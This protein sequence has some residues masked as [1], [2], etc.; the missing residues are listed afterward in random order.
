[1]C[2]CSWVRL[3]STEL[4][5]VGHY[6]FSEMP[7]VVHCGRAKWESDAMHCVSFNSYVVFQEKAMSTTPGDGHYDGGYGG[8]GGSYNDVF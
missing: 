5:V 2:E 4:G 8:V 7:W 3:H 6:F 1:M